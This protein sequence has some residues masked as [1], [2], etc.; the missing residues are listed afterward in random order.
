[1]DWINDRVYWIERGTR[2][3]RVYDLNTEVVS[4]V[5][6]LP[7]SSISMKLKVLPHIG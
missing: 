3:I 1:M 5:T 6:N 7:P 2:I 4:T